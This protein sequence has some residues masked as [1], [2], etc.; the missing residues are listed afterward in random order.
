MR[1]RTQNILILVIAAVLC[2]AQERVSNSAS[3]PTDSAPSTSLTGHLEAPAANYILGPEDQITLFVSDVDEINNKVLRVDMKGDI[4]VPLA[5]RI[6]AAGLSA[7]GLQTE[8]ESRLKKFLQDPDVVV[9][10]TE[11]RS[12][13]IS[14][15]GAVQKPGV[16]QLE[17]RKTLYEVLSLGGGLTPDA[18]DTVK[19]TRALEWGPIPLPG[20]KQ[21]SSGEFSIASVSVRSIMDA[22]NAAEN[23]MIKPEDVISVP[24]ADLVYCVGSVHKP[25]GFVLGQNESLSALQV[26]ALAEGLDKGAAPD[27]AKILRA[28]PGESTRSEIEV[29]L[30]KLMAGKGQDLPLKAQD[31]LFIPNSAAK[32]AA[33]RTAEAA[34]QIA[35][36]VAIYGRY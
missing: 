35:T 24:K 9:N 14:V 28:V 30:K 27:R 34:I 25:G 22:S 31:I 13:P 8:I 10:V 36:G 2:S 4:N 15:L 21:D 29:N 17:G 3:P 1:F 5:G 12:Q 26:L 32:S 18:G 16:Y 20:A 6:H 23:I 11:Y 33:S 7:D 19:I